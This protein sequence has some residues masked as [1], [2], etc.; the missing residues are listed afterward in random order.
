M[1]WRR[2]GG[3]RGRG[4]RAGRRSLDLVCGL[5]RRR[6]AEPGVEQDGLAARR[7]EFDAGVPVPGESQLRSSAI[8]R[9]PQGWV[10]SDPS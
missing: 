8:L 6:V 9:P 10:R 2:R 5:G 7:L 1:R 4:S 3:R